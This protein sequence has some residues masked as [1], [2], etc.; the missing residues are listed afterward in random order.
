MN[1]DLMVLILEIIYP[2]GWGT[3]GGEGIY[4]KS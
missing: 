4:N 1:Q 3:G 2:K